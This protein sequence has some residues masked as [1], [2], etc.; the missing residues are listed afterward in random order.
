MTMS[1]NFMSIRCISPTISWR[2]K[3][4][5]KFNH[6]VKKENFYWGKTVSR[7]FAV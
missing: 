4:V 7:N 2:N 3:L 6:Y 1:N 5:E